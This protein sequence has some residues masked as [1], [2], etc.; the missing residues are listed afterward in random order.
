MDKR[1]L[2]DPTPFLPDLCRAKNVLY[3][4]LVSQLLAILLA[5]NTSFIAGDFWI[6]LSLNALFILWVA[7]TCAGIFCLF[8]Q[9]INRFSTTLASLSMLLTINLSTLLMTWVTSSLLP[10]LD[11]LIAPPSGQISLYLR[12]VGI[13]SIFSIILLRFLYIQ[14]QWQKQTKAEAEAQ[15]D[16]LQALIR[17][18]FLF[19]SLNTIASLTRSN[20]PLAESLTEDLS[21]LFRANM[22]TSQRLIPFKQ[23]LNLIRQYL[24]IEQNRLGSR[25][26]IHLDLSTIPDDALIPPLSLQPLTENAV[27]HRIEPA[28]EGG[29]LSL[30]GKIKK[31][32]V[33]LLIKNPICNDSTPNTR[34]GN[35][36]AI[37]NVRFRME[38]CFPD[39]SK[40]LI[41]SSGLEFQT[42]LVFP[43]HNNQP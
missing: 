19:N 26:T 8:K 4:A 27:F 31:N 12:N 40:L 16:A 41:S 35:N 17:P 13:S 18:H 28:P 23:E 20:P 2:T 30:T 25:L 21:E 24:N 11:L 32:T 5:L 29:V 9:Q 15:L 38:Q 36:M 3:L 34:P 37:N 22:Q 10:A 7:F 33:Y 43:Y 39:Q 14:F 1:S 42:Q 6:S